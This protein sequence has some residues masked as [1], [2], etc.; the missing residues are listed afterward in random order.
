MSPDEIVKK[1]CS[2]V[3]ASLKYN[4]KEY[5][6]EHFAT[7]LRYGKAESCQVQT[8]QA[9]GAAAAAG[10]GLLGVAASVIGLSQGASN[11]TS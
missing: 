8:V 10:G 2:L 5:N 4:L 9:I 3:G 1:A 6:C 11:F 7:E